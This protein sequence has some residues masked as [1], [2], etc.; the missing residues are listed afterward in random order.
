MRIGTLA[1]FAVV[2]A[3]T[4]GS[5]LGQGQ[6]RGRAKEKEKQTQTGGFGGLGMPRLERLA[7]YLG[8]TDQQL[9]DAQAIFEAAQAEEDKIEPQL[10]ETREKIQALVKASTAEYDGQ[11]QALITSYASL[12]AEELKIQT[13]AMNRLWNLLTVQQKD[14]AEELDKFLKPV[15]GNG[16]KPAEPPGQVKKNE[17][18]Q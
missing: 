13:K 16:K 14:K 7:E 9:K 11:I 12:E 17:D 6:G 10:T 8:F 2:L 5:A 4:A 1:T 18:E 3:L 15:G